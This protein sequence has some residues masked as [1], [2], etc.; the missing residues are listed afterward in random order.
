MKQ[1]KAEKYLI[2]IFIC[3]FLQSLIIGCT[4][5]KRLHYGKKPQTRL[6][7]GNSP[8][9]I[10]EKTRFMG[11]Q[12]EM[13]SFAFIADPQIG[14]ESPLGL[15]G[16]R[17]DKER[18]DRAI[19]YVN[20]NEVAFVIFGGDQ[21]HSVDDES[22]DAQ[23]DVF[24]ECV[25]KLTVPYYGVIG[26]HEQCD[27]TLPIE[28]CAPTQSCKYVERGL[29]VRFSFSYGNASFV[30]INCLWLRGDFGNEYMQKE[31]DYLET[32]FSKLPADCEHRFV[33]MHWPLFNSH[34]AEESTCWN[35]PNRTQLIDLFKKYK[36]TCVLSGHWH[37][38]IAASWNGISFITSVG[39]STFLHHPEEP[40]F[41]IFTVFSGGWSV[42]RIAVASSYI[43]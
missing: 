18:L 26:N 7:T 9:E 31:L 17:S 2:R 16:P 25:S 6:N 21:I 12:K 23:L 42:Q 39:T 36:V 30:G 41:K 40:S 19:E 34:P 11:R 5:E 1:N 29:P 22:T 32:H 20:N 33:V 3:F 43:K 13:F 35:M 24:E 27:A 8:V 10:S 37:Q 28:Q 4:M 15:R 38:D 14:M